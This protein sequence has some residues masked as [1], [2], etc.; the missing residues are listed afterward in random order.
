[1]KTKPY[2]SIFS[3]LYVL[4]SGS[5]GVAMAL[6]MFTWKYPASP[7]DQVGQAFVA[8]QPFYI[9]VFLFAVLCCLL[10]VFILPVWVLLIVLLK[11]RA[12]NNGEQKTRM[13][14]ILILEGVF[15]TVIVFT[16]LQFMSS[17][18]TTVKL[19]DYVPQGHSTRMLF[20][21][22]FTFLTSLPALLGIMLIHTAAGELST[23]IDAAGQTESQLFPLIDELISYR[24]I[25]Q[26]YLTVLGIILSMLPI[27]TAGLRA[28]L[29]TL[30]PENEQNFPITNAILFGLV[31]TMLLL[32]IYVP[33][34]LALTEV[35]RKLRDHLCPLDS[36]TSLKQDIEQRKALDDLLQTN[37]GITQNLKMGLITLAPLATSL[38]SSLFKVNIPL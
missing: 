26:N 27:T 36:L 17:I 19:A 35:S 21:Y 5:L 29:I 15:L 25:L 16:L 18:Q 12:A 14:L 11:N 32:L 23:K 1:M 28:I 38:L 10:T 34:H 24:N 9:W 30:N 22:I 7:D 37:I 4:L 3:P 33:T 31:F 20:M 8:A 6:A 13:I 2:S